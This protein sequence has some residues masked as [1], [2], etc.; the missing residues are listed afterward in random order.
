ML[1]KNKNA[2]LSKGQEKLRSDI[3][4]GNAVTPVGKNV[5]AP[6]FEPGVPVKLKDYEID[7][8]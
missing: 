1:A 7:R 5:A 4:V 2:K 3:K 6:D 8:H